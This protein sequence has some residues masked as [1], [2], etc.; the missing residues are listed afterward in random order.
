MAEE[1]LIDDDKDRKYKIRINEDGEEEL[2]IDDTPDEEESDI[3]VFQIPV[4]DEDDE[5]AASLS[6]QEFAEREKRK[7]EEQEARESKFSSLTDCAYAKLADG[8]YE[9]AL[10]AV[11]QAEEL[12]KDSGQLYCLKLNILTRGFTDYISDEKCART[13]EKIAL[14]STAEQKAEIKSKLSGLD[15]R[16]AEAEKRTDEL[17]KVN[18]EKKAERREFFTAKKK[19]AVAACIASVTPFVLF[20]ILTAVFGG[21]MFSDES[22]L[23][24]IITVVFAALACVALV[25]A[26]LFANSLLSARKNVVL[27]ESDDSTEIGREYLASQKILK[28]LKTV[29]SAVEK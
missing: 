23:F 6:P 12:K 27:N 15:E 2:V 17:K 29:K 9:S 4:Y 14:Y 26:L 11:T 19:K 22:G 10:Y 1:R 18:E 28:N 8:D 20:I 3:P 25:P 5:D 7:K 13:A 21:I 24:I 16:I